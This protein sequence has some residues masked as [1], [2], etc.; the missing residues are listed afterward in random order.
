M[1]LPQALDGFKIGLITDP[2]I[3]D[4]AA[5]ERLVRAVDTLNEAQV[6]LQ[7]MGGDLLDDLSLIET[8]FTALERS[9]AP[10][11]HACCPG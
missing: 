5:P 1:A 6:H 2:H 10:T 3:G 11:W 8:S 4:W 9:R 7:V